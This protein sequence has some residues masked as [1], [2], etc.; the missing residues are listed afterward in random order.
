MT[1]V[2]KNIMETNWITGNPQNLAAIF[3]TIVV[4]AWVTTIVLTEVL[5]LSHKAK[6]DAAETRVRLGCC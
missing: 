4:V 5:P 3:A 2:G 1:T 6:T